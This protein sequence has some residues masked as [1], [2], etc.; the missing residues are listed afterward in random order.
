MAKCIFVSNKTK[1]ITKDGV[2]Y[3]IRRLTGGEKLD[4][5]DEIIQ[6]QFTQDDIKKAKDNPERIQKVL[7]RSGTAKLLKIKKALVKWD[8]IDVDGKPALI[9]LTNIR[10]LP[11]THL[12]F[13]EEEIDK[14]DEEVDEKN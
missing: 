3:T 10:R 6:Y 5:Q 14:M 2:T 11:D 7:A 13:L 8:L 1:D 4:I 9:T 12:D